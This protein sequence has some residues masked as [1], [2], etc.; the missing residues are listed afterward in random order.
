MNIFAR[1][2]HMMYIAAAGERKTN[3]M[4]VVANNMTVTPRRRGEKEEVRRIDL[5][6]LHEEFVLIL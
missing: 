1:I 5:R 2:I 6:Y 4:I 3:S